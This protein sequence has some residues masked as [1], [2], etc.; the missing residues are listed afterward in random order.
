MGPF[1]RSNSGHSG[2][3]L[4]RLLGMTATS[5]SAAQTVKG[6]LPAC[7]ALSTRHPSLFKQTLEP[8]FRIRSCIS[9]W[10]QITTLS[11]FHSILV[12]VSISAV[13][14]A[15][16]QSDSPRLWALLIAA[17]SRFSATQLY[18]VLK[19]TS[20]LCSETPSNTAYVVYPSRIWLS[21]CAGWNSGR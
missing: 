11:Y 14:F 9:F 8:P 13:N 4:A 1:N 20:L 10:T 15:F 6:A 19:K 7:P 18:F 21:R 5:F 3:L 12:L 16:R 2:A 17:A